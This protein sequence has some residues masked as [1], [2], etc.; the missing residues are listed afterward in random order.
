MTKHVDVIKRKHALL[1]K[2]FDAFEEGA[3][4]RE[5]AEISSIPRS[6]YIKS[7][8]TKHM[9]ASNMSSSFQRTIPTRAEERL[10]VEFLKVYSDNGHPLRRSEITDAVS[11]MIQKLLEDRQTRIC[12]KKG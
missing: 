8:T 9:G 5:A 2:A 12:F 10:V 6:K 4:V 3:T 11:L 7:I 1:L